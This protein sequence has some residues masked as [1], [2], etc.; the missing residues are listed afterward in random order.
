MPLSSEPLVSPRLP[1][2][3]PALSRLGFDPALLLTLHLGPDADQTSG[4][5]THA[6]PALPR[7]VGTPTKTWLPPQPVVTIRLYPVITIL[8]INLPKASRAGGSRSSPASDSPRSGHLV[9][10][11]L[12]QVLTHPIESASLTS[13]R[14]PARRRHSVLHRQRQ[15]LLSL[16]A[17]LVRVHLRAHAMRHQLGK[18]RASRAWL[19][20]DVPQ[21]GFGAWWAVDWFPGVPRESPQVLAC[22]WH[23]FLTRQLAVG[24]QQPRLVRP[25]LRDAAR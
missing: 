14:V 9:L 6:L 19:R 10:A 20:A 5:T 8:D 4:A 17:D 3:L 16:R 22:E 2:F 23:A 21:S 18:P 15:Q 11:R 13:V 7:D 1:G 12:S 25:Q 24:I